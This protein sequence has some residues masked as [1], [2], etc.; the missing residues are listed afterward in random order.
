MCNAFNHPSWC[1]CGWGGEGHAGQPGEHVES[2]VNPNARCP[3]CGVSVFFY[4]SPDGGRV[5]FDELGPPWPKHPCTSSW[6]APK[7]L[8]PRLPARGAPP[9]EGYAWQR[10]GWSPF[11]VTGVFAV[12]KGIL[13][14][15]GTWRDDPVTVY[16]TYRKGFDSAERWMPGERLLAMM[17]RREHRDY[18][19]CYEVSAYRGANDRRN[20]YAFEMH[21]EARRAIERNDLLDEGPSGEG[22]TRIG[23]PARVAR[24]RTVVAPAARPGRQPMTGRERHPAQGSHAGNAAARNL[25]PG[26]IAKA[27]TEAIEQQA[28][29]RPNSPNAD[30]SRDWG[31]G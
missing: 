10:E 12:D 21:W 1:R 25:G 15:T 31:Q 13:R 22:K 7:L 9:R 19:G 5:Y 30:V 24:G 28:G 6:P 3:V 20:V 8:A 14:L 23:P 26:A 16:A 4:Q 29:R 18:Q 17:R 2:Y 27:L 11:L